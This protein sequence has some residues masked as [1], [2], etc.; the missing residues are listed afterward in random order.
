MRSRTAGA[1]VF[2]TLFLSYAWFF[3]GGGYNPNSRLALTR[4]LAEHGTLS[5]DAYPVTGDWAE[6]GGRRYANKAPG[7]SFLAAPVWPLTASIAPE[8]R[9]FGLSRRAWVVNLAVNALPAALLGWLLFTALGLLRAGSPRLRA[10][11]ALAYGLGTLAFPYATAFYAH[12]PAAAAGFAA[13][14]ALL[15]GEGASRP[16]HLAVVAGAC[17]GLAVTLETSTALVVL[18]L[19]AW[20]VLDPRRRGLLLPFVIGGLPF[21]L[22]LGAYN[23]TAFGS[24]WT[25]WVA[26]AN[27]A[28][29]VRVDG[30]LFGAPSLGNAVALLVMPYRGLFYTSPVLLL[31]LAGWPLLWRTRPGVSLLCA[32]IP[33]AFLVVV[34]GFHAWYGGWA[35]GARYLVPALPFLFV[36]V[37]F[38]LPRWPA[39]S[40][41]LAAVSIACMLVI[42][43]VAVEIPADFANPLLD[44]ALPRFLAGEVAVNPQL[45]DVRLPPATYG[46]GQAATNSA[47][48]NLG[49]LAGLHGLIG[50]APLV[51]L[52]A[53]AGFALALGGR[54]R[55]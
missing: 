12:Q 3:Q 24:P 27:P 21:A 26:H 17:A 45:L 11:A 51:A 35:P 53:A 15:A 1:L 40:W 41:P 28:V 54:K 39:V 44:F 49:E 46:T 38:G 2:A 30:R 5:I 13:F 43:A 52:W 22:A 34:S 37:A 9:G 48:F 31:A 18:G 42:T 14:T 32:G 8:G 33:L 4:A 55:V 47:S 16:R 36:P 10:A 19:G 7:L 25:L 50:L 29:E 23:A 6:H 20:L